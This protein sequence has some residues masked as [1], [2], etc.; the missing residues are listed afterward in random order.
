MDLKEETKKNKDKW[1]NMYNKV[2]TQIAS[3]SSPDKQAV[4]H[5]YCVN[6]TPI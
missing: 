6:L 4:G 5:T 2:E 3:V 1:K